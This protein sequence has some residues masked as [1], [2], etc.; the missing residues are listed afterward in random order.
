ML[1]VCLLYYFGFKVKCMYKLLVNIN[2]YC[3]V[4]VIEIIEDMNVKMISLKIK[5]V[6]ILNFILLFK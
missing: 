2:C 5:C 4:L 6:I 1:C 3:N